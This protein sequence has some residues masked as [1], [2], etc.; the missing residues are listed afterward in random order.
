MI[1]PFWAFLLKANQENL[2]LFF[3]QQEQTFNRK[4]NLRWVGI[5][6]VAF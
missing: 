4:M 6:I 2:P 3:N 5:R 1:L